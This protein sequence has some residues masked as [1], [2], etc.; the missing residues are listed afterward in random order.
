MILDH[1]KVDFEVEKG[2][3]RTPPRPHLRVEGGK[4]GGKPNLEDLGSI[5]RWGWPPGID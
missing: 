5:A 1:E 3:K 2:G 4:G